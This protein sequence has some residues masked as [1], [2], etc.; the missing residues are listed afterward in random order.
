[1]SGAYAKRNGEWLESDAM[2]MSHALLSH[3]SRMAT[4]C[5]SMGLVLP[6]H[7]RWCCVYTEE[8]TETWVAGNVW[9][10]TWGWGLELWLGSFVAGCLSA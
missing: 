5:A 6:G 3:F 2:S 10:E 1:M 4:G 9:L 7:C 8:K